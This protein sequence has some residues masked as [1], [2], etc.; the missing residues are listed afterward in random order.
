MSLAEPEGTP[1]RFR[2]Q[3]REH[4]VTRSWGPE[5]IETGWWRSAAVRRDY[6]RVEVHTGHWFWLFHRLE[7][8]DWFLHG[9]FD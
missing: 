4:R 8:R 9:A 5:R 2:W 6:F 7:E 1:V 3:Q